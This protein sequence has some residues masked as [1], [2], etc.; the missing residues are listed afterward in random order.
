MPSELL[1]SLLQKSPEYLI[2]FNK[3]L[4]RAVIGAP[5]SCTHND[6]FHKRNLN[7]QIKK[8]KKFHLQGHQLAHVLL[9]LFLN[10][11]VNGGKG[12][13]LCWSERIAA[14]V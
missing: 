4:R 5:H 11:H 3:L 9:G 14:L 7:L 12:R 8:K 13:K 2:A 1:H 10:S 6:F